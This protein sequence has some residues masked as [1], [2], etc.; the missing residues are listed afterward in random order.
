MDAWS[1]VLLFILFMVSLLL[2][3]VFTVFSLLAFSFSVLD[4]GKPW[5]GDFCVSPSPLEMNERFAFEGVKKAAEID[6]NRDDVE[7]EDDEDDEDGGGKEDDNDEDDDYSGEGEGDSDDG[8]E[9]NNNAAGS[10]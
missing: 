3:L 6:E 10:G 8:M 9:A 1:S 5:L 2:S 7:S 4:L